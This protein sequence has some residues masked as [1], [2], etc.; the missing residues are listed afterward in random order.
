MKKFI[1]CEMCGQVIV[2]Y[3]KNKK[4]CTRCA[5]KR[6]KDRNRKREELP[7]EMPKAEPRF[8]INEIAKMQEDYQKRTGQYISYGKL[9]SMIDQTYKSQGIKSR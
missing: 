4:F 7:E 5:R 2:A 1:N 3:S 9:V 8:S 6:A